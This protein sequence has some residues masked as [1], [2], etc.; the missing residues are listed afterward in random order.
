MI[1]S[2]SLQAMVKAI[3]LTRGLPPVTR[4]ILLRIETSGYVN[5]FEKTPCIVVASPGL[6]FKNRIGTKNILR[7]CF[8]HEELKLCQ[9]RAGIKEEDYKDEQVEVKPPFDLANG[10]KFKHSGNVGSNDEADVG[11]YQIQ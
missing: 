3:S 4:A 7:I 5:R 9:C 11:E 1:T 6:P 10:V 8:F 2:T